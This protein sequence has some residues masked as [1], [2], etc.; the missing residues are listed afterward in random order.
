[1]PRSLCPNRRIPVVLPEDMQF[2]E[3]KRPTFYVQALTCRQWLEFSE[4]YDAIDKAETL[5]DKY[6]VRL[7]IAQRYVLGWKN[8]VNPE[9]GEA[10]AFNVELLADLVDQYELSILVEQ[11]GYGGRL[12]FEDKKNSASPPCSSTDNCASAA[13][14]ESAST[15][16][17]DESPSKFPASY[18]ADETAPPPTAPS[19]PAAKE[20]DTTN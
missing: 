2:A 17:A 19:A 11:I 5:R 13:S 9:T 8:L 4:L 16:P 1:M 15:S 6:E 3:E 18:V 20:Q 7:T 10:I 12:E 14:A